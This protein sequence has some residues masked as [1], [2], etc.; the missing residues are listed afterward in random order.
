MRSEERQVTID[1]WIQ[2]FVDGAAVPDFP[3]CAVQWLS[4]LD[5]IQLLYQRRVILTAY[6][7]GSDDSEHVNIQLL[8]SSNQCIESA[9]LRVL[10]EI[11]PHQHCT[12]CLD[13]KIGSSK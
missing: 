8:E 11:V 9:V 7:Q 5:I 10:S 1:S 4:L 3:S 2:A 12:G 6:S 13:F